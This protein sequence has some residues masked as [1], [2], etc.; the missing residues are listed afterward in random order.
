MLFH[1]LLFHRIGH[2]CHRFPELFEINQTYA[3]TLLVIFTIHG[4]FRY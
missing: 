2:L 3:T 1:N 4:K